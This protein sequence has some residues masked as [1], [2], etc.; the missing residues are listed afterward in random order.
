VTPGRVFDPQ[1]RPSSGLRLSLSRTSGEQVERGIAVLGECA[2]EWLA[3]SD[4][5]RR[6]NFL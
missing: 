6:P 5:F 2:R 3:S 1:A 4:P